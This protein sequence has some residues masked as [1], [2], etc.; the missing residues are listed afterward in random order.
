MM[1]Q[2]EITLIIYIA[3]VQKY[4]TFVAVLHVALDK[5]LKLRT[6]TPSAQNKS[7][8]VQHQSAQSFQT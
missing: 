3:Y 8:N 1:W 7:A 2:E 4:F 6:V 5:D